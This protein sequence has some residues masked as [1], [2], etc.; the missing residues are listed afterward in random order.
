LAAKTPLRIAA[1]RPLAQAVEQF[2]E[3]ERIDKANGRSSA[4]NAAEL[5]LLAKACPSD[6]NCPRPPVLFQDNQVIAAPIS[7]PPDDLE[8][9]PGLRM[10]GMGDPRALAGRPYT[11]RNR[12]LSPRPRSSSRR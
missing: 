2:G 11:G 10:K 12:R 4:S 9:A 5:V 1:P 6:G 3:Q 7:T 8:F